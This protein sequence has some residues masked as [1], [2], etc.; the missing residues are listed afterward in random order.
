[1]KFSALSLLHLACAATASQGEFAMNRLMSTKLNHWSKARTQG[2][3]DANRYPDLGKQKCANGTAGEYSCENVDLLGFLSH[4]AMGS[5]TREGNDIWGWTSP[6]DREFGIVGQSDGTAFVEV[7]KDGSIDYLGRLPT[8]TQ[9]SPWRDMKVIGDHV[10]IGSE[11]NGHGLQVFDLKKLLEL[12]ANEP[13]TFSISKDLKAWYKGFGSSHNIVAHPETNMIYAVGTDRTLSCRGGLWMVDVS[14]PAKP[15]SPGCVSQDGY[16]HDAQCVI[17]KGPD[18]KYNGRE[19]CFNYNEKALTIVDVTNKKAPKQ[20][21]KTSYT[22]F[23]YTHQGWVIDPNDMS[24]LLLDDELDETDKTGIAANGHTTTY[25]FDIKNLAS[26]KHTG[27]YQSPVKSIDHNQYVV[28]GLS[29]QSN[30]G[31]GLRI[32]DVS[33]VAQDPTGKEFKQVGFFDCHPEDD[34]QGGEVKFFGSWSVYPYFKSG[35]ILLNSI[36]RGVYSLK[37]NG[38]K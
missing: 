35:S 13:T 9:S 10:Y 36:E 20:I 16:V 6:N 11:A 31:S 2:M 25:I 1:M 29:Y 37:Y 24:Y 17:Y 32:V 33:S 4:Q 38:A 22:G 3:F 12:D 34:A 7:H 27:S 18:T 23:A 30:Y 8:Q 28:N 21:S 26:P 19:I 14:N 15:T 5:E